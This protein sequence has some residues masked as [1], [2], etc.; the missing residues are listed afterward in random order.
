MQGLAKKELTHCLPARNMSGLSC[1]GLL[2]FLVLQGDGNIVLGAEFLPEGGETL[3]ERIVESLFPEVLARYVF[4]EV[5]VF[6]DI[7]ED[8][9][10][11]ATV[12]DGLFRCLVPHES[13]RLVRLQWHTLC[14]TLWELV[15]W[16][17]TKH[18]PEVS[19]HRV[20]SPSQNMSETTPEEPAYLY[21]KASLVICVHAF[22]GRPGS[23]A[24]RS[25]AGVTVPAGWRQAS[26]P[27]LRLEMK[28]SW[29]RAGSR[30]HG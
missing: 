9:E 14:V 10:F 27:A 30:R 24:R 22:A 26:P 6:L 17:N 8:A 4:V 12:V 7:G 2:A 29:G 15:V 18:A 20:L 5:A 13:D 21:G 23:G 1:L 11:H 28:S 19:S 25:A 16:L 3:F